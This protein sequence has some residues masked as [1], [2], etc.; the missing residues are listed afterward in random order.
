MEAAGK[1]FHLITSDPRIAYKKGGR[2]PQSATGVCRCQDA[3]DQTFSLA[4]DTMMLDKAGRRSVTSNQYV[5]DIQD[6]L[7]AHRSIPPHTPPSAMLSA[8]QGS[9]ASS[10]DGM[11]LLLLLPGLLSLGADLCSAA[12]GR[13]R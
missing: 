8:W 13:M 1:V 9:I 7:M 3:A 6:F 10:I 12:G 5:T 2:S 11:A 4:I